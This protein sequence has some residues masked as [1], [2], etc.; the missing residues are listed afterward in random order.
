VFGVALF[1][2]ANYGAMVTELPP[3]RTVLGPVATF[4]LGDET[5]EH[6]LRLFNSI[7]FGPL[8]V[9]VVGVVMNRVLTRPELTEI[10]LIN[11]ALP[12]RDPDLV[13]V[14]SAALGTSFY[15]TV[16]TAATGR[17]VLLP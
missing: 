9:S 10:P 6:L 16:V 3:P 1:V 11:P 12:R 2:Y 13:V 8:L 7:L 15:L 4:T 5:T 14:T 17:F